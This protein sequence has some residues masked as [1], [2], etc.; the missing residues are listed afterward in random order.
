MTKFKM[1]RRAVLRGAGVTIAM[2]WLESLQAAS[3][4]PKRFGVL[5][6]GC[7]IN[8][9]HWSA[10]GAGEAMELSQTLQVMAPLKK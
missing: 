7:G 8:E 10:K 4:P 2:P 5:F 1:S 3:T 6:M 9:D